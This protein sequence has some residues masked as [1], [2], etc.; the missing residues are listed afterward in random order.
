MDG[1]WYGVAEG[2]VIGSVYDDRTVDHL[3]VKIFRLDVTVAVK[4]TLMVVRSKPLGI[5]I[6]SI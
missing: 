4:E 1:Y 3:D 5:V 6:R 2:F